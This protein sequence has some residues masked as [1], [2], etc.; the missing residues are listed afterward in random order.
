MFHNA[1]PGRQYPPGDGDGLRDGVSHSQRDQRKK[2]APTTATRIGQYHPLIVCT[3]DKAT[4]GDEV[5]SSRNE[6]CAWADVA[7][8]RNEASL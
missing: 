4:S 2:T 8:F 5:L 1:W 6:I 3:G 7:S